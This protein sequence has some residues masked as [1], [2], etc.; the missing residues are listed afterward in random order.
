MPELPEAETIARQL[1][2][3]LCGRRL[4][5][6]LHARRDMVHGDP[7]PLS[8]ILPGLKII[9][10]HRRAKRVIFDLES[11]V[12]LI[13]HLGMS[14]QLMAMESRQPIAKHTHLRVSIKKTNVELRFRDPRRFGGIW[15]E[16]GSVKHKGK[17]LGPLGPEPLEI[18]PASF[19]KLLDRNRQ[20]KALLLDQ[21][22]IVGVGNIYCDESLH[23]AGIHPQ[24]KARDL[25]RV[26]ADRLLRS[27]K[28]V[29]HRAIKFNGSTFMDYQ[30]ANGDDGSFQKQHR[31]YNKEGLPCKTCGVEI[32]RMTVA[33]RSS[34]V[35]PQ[36]QKTRD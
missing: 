25:D 1:H 35:C 27:I 34:F 10:I 17:K 16:T 21:K 24:Q 29:L 19:R 31:V 4:D 7:R 6:V 2:D 11:S 30:T 33:G 28:S 14:G 32:L 23:A 5:K 12:Q 8:K 22:M 18:T 9:K 26:A 13:F 15:C 36:C 20:I 3:R